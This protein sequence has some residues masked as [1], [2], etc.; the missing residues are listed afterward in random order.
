MNSL[1]KIV[2]YLPTILS[3]IICKYTNTCNWKYWTLLKTQNL[4]HRRECFGLGQAKALEVKL[5]ILML[6]SI[7]IC[8]AIYRFL[9]SALLVSFWLSIQVY[10]KNTCHFNLMFVLKQFSWCFTWLTG[11]ASE[12]T[13]REHKFLL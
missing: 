2:L 5:V 1:I 7:K 9:P 10:K 13:I 4:S 8:G 12:K 6:L 3:Y 11:S